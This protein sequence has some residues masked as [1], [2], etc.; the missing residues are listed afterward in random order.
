[1]R[2]QSYWHEDY[3]DG[4]KNMMYEFTEHPMALDWGEC[5]KRG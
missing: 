4:G 2:L 3:F 1:M 5:I